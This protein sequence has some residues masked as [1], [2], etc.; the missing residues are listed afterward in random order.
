MRKLLLLPIL[1]L[2]ITMGLMA[3]TLV[4]TDPQGKNVVLE[5]FTGIHCQYCPDGHRIAQGIA[6]ANPG[7]VVLI[8]IHQGSYAVPSGSEPDYRTPFGD[9]LAA[10]TGLTGYPSGTVNRHV[11]PGLGMTTNGTAMG[12]SN[13]GTASNQILAQTS[14]VNVGIETSYEPSTRLL[15]V[16]VEL[17]Y[18]AN[19]SLST[20]NINVALLQDSVLGPQTN[21]GAGNNYVHMHMLRYLVTGQWG[22][23]VANTTQGSLV[24]RTYT[25][26]IPA[27]YNSIPCIVEH[28]QVAAYVTE[29]HQEVLSGD[30]VNAIGGSNRYIGKVNTTSDFKLG[31]NGITSDFSCQATGSLVSGSLYKFSLEPIN[32]VSG[33]NKSFTIDGTQYTDTAIVALNQNEAKDFS[34]SIIPGSTAAVGTYRLSM[35]SVTYPA[36][37]PKILDLTVISGITDLVVNGSGGPETTQ[38]QGVYLDGLTQAGCTT[39]SAMSATMMVKAFNNDAMTEV[40]NIY[41]NVAWTFPAFKDDEATALKSLMDAGHNVL[42]AGQDVGW[43]VMSGASGSNGDAITQD[44]YTNYLSARWIDDGSSANNQI[45]AVVSDTIFGTA[46]N[47]TVTDVYA[48]NMYPDQIDTISPAVPIFLYKGLNTKRA[49]LR[50]EKNGYKSVYFGVGFEMLS[51][52]TVRNKIIQLVYEWFNGDHTG[53]EFD[54][55]VA[56]IM[57]QNYPNP[58]NTYTILPLNN[59]RKDMTMLFVDMQGRKI[60]TMAVHPG[61]TQLKVN[62]NGWTPGNYSYI[63]MDGNT[64]ISAKQ[65]AV[66]H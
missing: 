8:N 17:Y 14:P 15:T 60:S 59:I 10:Q 61:D 21:G 54:K 49:A 24:T 41:F 35:A 6:D 34:V 43:D 66:I 9:A 52:V 36:A 5:E 63:L 12:R 37:P 29:S 47:S 33:W 48:G 42:V 38:Y 25:Y 55:A 65:L 20:N 39:S 45:T 62:T 30:V 32:P 11:F 2:T 27:A 18:T 50:V 53:I 19:S 13:W 58:G 40:N 26:T 51:T 57:G 22:D 28:C 46:G 23:P 3:Q 7:R 4:S 56:A 44:L 16:N 31:H 1:I 64:L